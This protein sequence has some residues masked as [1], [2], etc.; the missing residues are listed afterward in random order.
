MKKFFYSHPDTVIAGLA[1]IL[2]AVLL[3]FY[4]WASNDVFSEVHRALTFS[5]A[6]SESSFNI[7]AAAKLDLRGLVNGSSS[8]VAAPAPLPAPALPAAT[9][10]ATSTTPAVASG[11]VSAH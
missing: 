2:F 10:T 6:S 4:L 5:P 1:L 8:A 7:S 3:G 11:T 9:T